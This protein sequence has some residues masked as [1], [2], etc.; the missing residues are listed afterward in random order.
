MKNKVSIIGAGF[1]GTMTAQKI[2]EKN[3]ADV[4]L[5]DI[6]EGVPQGKA[7][8]IS[9]SSSLEEFDAKITGTNDFSEIEGSDIVVVTAGFPRSPGMT[10]EELGLKNGNVVKSVTEK[11][12]EFAPE[13]IIIIVT[14]PLDVMTHLAWKISGFHDSKVVGMGG[15]LDTARY[16]YFLAEELNV[17]VKDIE[18]LVLGSHGDTMIPVDSYTTLK[19]IPVSQFIKNEKLNAIIERTK[20]GGAEIV[21]LLKSGSAW[22]GPS[23]SIVVMIEAILRDSKRVLPASAYL[24]GEYGIEGT[25]IGVPVKLGASG[26]EEIYEIS[27]SDEELAALRLSADI[28]KETFDKLRI[29]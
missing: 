10:R 9:Q 16:K 5:I 7:L 17:S 19:G 1:V 12:K 24:N 18:A 22:H 13:C 11:I 25:H 4:A 6:I 3:L 28:T 26:V 23:S 14:N 15:V 29:L 8:D 20:T 27:L 21:K 2:V